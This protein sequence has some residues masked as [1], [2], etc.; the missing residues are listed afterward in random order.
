MP[1]AKASPPSA[2]DWRERRRLQAWKLHEAGWSQGKIAKELSV[3]QGA[4]SQWMRRAREGGG[5]DALYRTPPPGRRA[6]LT[7][8][9]LSELPGLLA[10]GA[11]AFGFRGDRWTTGRVAAVLN[12][13]FGVSYHPGHV[14]RLLKKCCPNWR[15]AGKASAGSK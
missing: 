2:Q 14:S 8:D 5:A 11:E 12:Q 13:V 6:G 3:T 7:E 1:N 10:R 15:A 4:V 9:Q